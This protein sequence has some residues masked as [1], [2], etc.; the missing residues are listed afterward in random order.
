MGRRRRTEPKRAEE[1]LKKPVRVR[2]LGWLG[3]QGQPRT[4]R[5]IGKALALSNAAVHYHVKLLEEAGLVQF[6]GT[7]PGPN[8]I[9]E[10]LYSA[11]PLTSK[12]TSMT[13]AEKGDFYLRYTLDAISE[14]HRE[15]EQLVKSD[16]ENARFIAGC[17]ETYATEKEM[18]AL[19]K[20]VAAILERFFE[21]HKQKKTGAMPFAITFGLFP[22]QGAGWDTST[23]IRVFEIPS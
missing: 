10:K 23:R 17:Y 6:E 5:E 11:K 20:E 13:A 18:I 16:W 2:I 14:I 12:Q 15:G 1:V 8:T 19:K 3:G 22:S 9:T 4:K 7:R 21:S